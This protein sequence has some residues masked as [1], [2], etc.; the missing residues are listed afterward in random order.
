MFLGAF[1]IPRVQTFAAGKAT[2]WLNETYD[3]GVSVDRVSLTTKGGVALNKVLIR[4]HR[5][6]TLMYLNT[7]NK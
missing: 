4:D 1:L 3:V 6:D 2:K 5:S 7:I